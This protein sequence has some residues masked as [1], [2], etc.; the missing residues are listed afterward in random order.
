MGRTRKKAQTYR[1]RGRGRTRRG[2]YEKRGG[3]WNRRGRGRR[4]RRRGYRRKW[5]TEVKRWEGLGAASRRNVQ[6]GAGV[7]A[8]GGQGSGKR[9]RRKRT[10]AK[11][12]KMVRGRK[13][14]YGGRSEKQRRKAVVGVREGEIRGK[15]DSREREEGKPWK[16]RRRETGG[17]TGR[18][19]R[20]V[21]AD[22]RRR[23]SGLV[24]S[25][26]EA[27][28][29]IEH[30]TIG[31][32]RENGE[33]TRRERSSQRRKPGQ[34]RRLRNEKVRDEREKK[35]EAEAQTWEEIERGPVRGVTGRRKWKEAEGREEQ[36]RIPS[37]RYVNYRARERVRREWPRDGSVTRPKAAW[38]T[39]GGCRR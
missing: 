29:R 3:S 7:T 20:E 10:A 1:G 34:G 2:A 23:T 25:L 12:V 14:R 18:W 15:R 28:Q 22:R 19:K 38:V 16:G 5:R 39:E 4:R 9:E 21:R 30:G 33:D 11:K 13:R 26:A 32:V 31:R 8:T 24:T 17:R 36:R 27:R 37:Y 35:R 6:R